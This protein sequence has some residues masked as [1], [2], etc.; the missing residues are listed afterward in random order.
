MS[1]EHFRLL[2]LWLRWQISENAVKHV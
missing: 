1:V 2:R